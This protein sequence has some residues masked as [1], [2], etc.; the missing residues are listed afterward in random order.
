MNAGSN[1]EYAQSI[2]LFRRVSKFPEETCGRSCCGWF[3]GARLP[4]TVGVTLDPVWLFLSL[5]PGGVGFVLFVYGK[6]L[7]RWPQLAGGI[8][9]M[10]YPLFTP[11]SAV[12]MSVGVV[13]CGA[14]WW[15]V[16]AGW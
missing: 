15:A 12:M 3:I 14:V 2:G 13:I 4:Y 10:V 9:L 5:I 16:R 1:N 11:N 6:K 8:L 7:Q